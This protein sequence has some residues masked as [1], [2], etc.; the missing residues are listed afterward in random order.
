M[1]GLSFVN[2]NSLI[3]SLFN[4]SHFCSDLLSCWFL[5]ELQQLVKNQ[6]KWSLTCFNKLMF[7]F[8]VSNLIYSFIL[9]F[10]QI[11]SIGLLGDV[12]LVAVVAKI[13]F[14]WQ[15]TVQLWFLKL[16]MDATCLLLYQ[17][18]VLL[19]YSFWDFVM[20]V[21]GKPHIIFALA[22][23]ME[24]VGPTK[25]I[26]GPEPTYFALVIIFWQLF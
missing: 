5:K 4:V 20:P 10:H 18:Q 12:S 2:K 16:E 21:G 8:S 25:L 22:L 11:C 13:I 17:P 15:I 9:S 1:F 6:S 3:L 7:G 26:N 23:L 24:E 14:E 19:F